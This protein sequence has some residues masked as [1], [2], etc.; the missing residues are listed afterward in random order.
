MLF[1]HLLSKILN[2]RFDLQAFKY[3]EFLQIN[4]LYSDRR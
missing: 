3:T 2:L 1:E 4:I